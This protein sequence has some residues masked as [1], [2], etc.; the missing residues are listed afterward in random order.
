MELD[1]PVLKQGIWLYA[2]VV[3]CDIRIVK[4]NW[5]YGT[6][7]YE[8]PPEMREDLQGEFYNL[9]FGSPVKRGG[10][11]SRGGCHLSLA[12]AVSEAEAPPTER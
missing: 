8:D 1:G 10:Y 4:H 3:M 6:G 2:G 7:D 5:R 9:E 11:P 12:E